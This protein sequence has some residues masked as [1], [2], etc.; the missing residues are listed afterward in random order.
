MCLTQRELSVPAGITQ[1]GAHPCLLLSL[2]T[3]G[4]P[5][6]TIRLEC[7]RAKLFPQLLFC[8]DLG[9]NLALNYHCCQISVTGIEQ[10]HLIKCF[11]ANP[12]ALLMMLHSDFCWSVCENINSVSL[13]SA[14]GVK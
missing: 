14:C 5:F 13:V 11:S 7:S 6:V 3:Q 2:S 8:Q 10:L 12:G 1:H 4:I 9:C